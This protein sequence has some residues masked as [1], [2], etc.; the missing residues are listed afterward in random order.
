MPI[1]CDWTINISV[2][3]VLR[4][5]GANPQVVR[6]R[7][8]G[9]VRLAE[10]ALTDGL[11]LAEPAAVYAIWDVSRV[12]HNRVILSGGPTLS[13]VLVGRMLSAA[14]AVAAVVCTIGSALETLS[15]EALSTDPPL[16]LA[17]DGV[18][19]AAVEALSMAICRYFG[20]WANVR[21]WQ[22]TP[23]LSPG[24]EGWPLLHG[25]AEIF[26]LL[27]ETAQAG[28]RLLPSGGMLPRK[29]LSLVIGLG[30]NVDASADM[31]DFC[32]SRH[33]CRHKSKTAA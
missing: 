25:Q 33:A 5:Q 18:G 28:I 2:D 11:P 12:Q 22:S 32:A 21:R 15:L 30:P 7:R 1:L 16:S 19:S 31:C 24:L 8:P 3:D 26:A 4:C 23:P 9:L 29:S 13:G 20:D 17:L 10:R 14:R 6:A 27:P